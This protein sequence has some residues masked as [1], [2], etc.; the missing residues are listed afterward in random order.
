MPR[1]PGIST[2]LSAAVRAVNARWLRI[3]EPHR[4]PAA[5]WLPLEAEI[6]AA[7]DAGDRQRA[8]RAI[9]AWREHHLFKFT[10]SLLNPQPPKGDTDDR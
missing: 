9:E 10:Q 1:L 7:C 6:E 4:P 5:V 2:E 8:L 3:P